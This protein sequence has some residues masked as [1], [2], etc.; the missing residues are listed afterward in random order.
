MRILKRKTI[1]VIVYVDSGIANDNGDVF[2]TSTTNYYCKRL[3]YLIF[4]V[5]DLV[6]VNFIS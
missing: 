6:S 4:C 5:K 1:L 2:Q 3:R